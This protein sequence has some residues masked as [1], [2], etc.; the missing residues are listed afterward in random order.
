M[1]SYGW[2]LKSF[3][4]WWVVYPVIYRVSYIPGGAGILP[5]TVGLVN[6]I[7]SLV[8]ELSSV[9]W[10]PNLHNIC[11]NIGIL[12]K[13][14]GW[15]WFEHETYMKP[16]H[17]LDSNQII[18][19]SPYITRFYVLSKLSWPSNQRIL[20][21]YVILQ[22][23]LLWNQKFARKKQSKALS[24]KFNVFSSGKYHPSPKR[25]EFP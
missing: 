11:L 8:L 1:D 6:H 18:L 16:R 15:T 25:F 12:P 13:L 9:V 19:N 5:S 4:S 10:T 3:T 17:D 24:R 7:F 22:A 14:R 21:N 23:Y 20:R 2:W